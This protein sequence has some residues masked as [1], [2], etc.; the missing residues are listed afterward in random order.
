[1]RL[2]NAHL[3]RIDRAKVCEYLLNPG[4]PRGA[5]KARFFSQFGFTAGSWE[6]L[7]SA[8]LEHGQAHDVAS[9]SET[10]FGRRYEI[11]GQVRTPDGRRPHIRTVWNIEPLEIA[12]RLITAYPL[13][14]ATR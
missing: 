11:D 12:P 10:A 5:P 2:P 1:M 6:I 3:A 13:W 14:R 7:V 9:H 8:L 4:H